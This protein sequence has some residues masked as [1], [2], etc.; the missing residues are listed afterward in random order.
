MLYIKE[1]EINI[2]KYLN[3][4]K[5]NINKSKLKITSDNYYSY[6]SNNKSL[7]QNNKN[8]IQE[9]LLSDNNNKENK[10]FSLME[11]YEYIKMLS[12]NDNKDEVQQKCKEIL[13][14]IDFTK[15]YNSII[16]VDILSI[17][18]KY[19]LTKMIPDLKS[20]LGNKK[21]LISSIFLLREFNNTIQYLEQVKSGKIN[22]LTKINL[23]IN[24]NN[25]NKE[26]KEN[27]NS[28]RV[29]KN[30]IL[31]REGTVNEMRK[32]KIGGDEIKFNNNKSMMRSKFLNNTS[33]KKISNSKDKNT[34]VN[35]GKKFSSEMKKLQE[36]YIQESVNSV[37]FELDE[38]IK[39]I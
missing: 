18:S 20:L 37:D 17:I 9:I 31:K 5:N 35:L 22:I 36:K 24:T 12:L 23:Y 10:V 16:I 3:V 29:S 15:N 27:K 14:K 8:I 34:G 19:N 6:K 1:N 33:N 28:K 39:N 21:N 2:N 13:L 25:I 4:H 7:N 38:T 11:K 30:I 26:N 32:Y